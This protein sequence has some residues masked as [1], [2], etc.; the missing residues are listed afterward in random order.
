MLH[1]EWTRTNDGRASAIVGSYEFRLIR[2][3]VK[4]DQRFQVG[5]GFPSQWITNAHT[6]HWVTLEATTYQKA[7]KLAPAAV[8]QLLEEAAAYR[9]KVIE[10]IQAEVAE[11]IA[12]MEK[13][14]K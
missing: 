1:I 6:W 2:S 5:G 9:L 13:I 7:V 8:A 12:L 11:Q 4:S 3:G 14:G 10:G